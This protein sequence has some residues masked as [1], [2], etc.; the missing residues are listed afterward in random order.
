[1]TYTIGGRQISLDKDL[2]E[3]E[4]D[5]IVAHSSLF[6]YCLNNSSQQ[7]LINLKRIIHLYTDIITIYSTLL[8]KIPNYDD[9]TFMT[10]KTKLSLL[11]L[12]DDFNSILGKDINGDKVSWEERSYDSVR[13]IALLCL[14][15]SNEILSAI[16]KNLNCIDIFFNSF[17]NLKKLLI[18]FLLNQSKSVQKSINKAIYFFKLTTIADD[19]DRIE[20]TDTPVMKQLK[21]IERITNGI[22]RES[23]ILNTAFQTF[24]PSLQQYTRILLGKAILKRNIQDSN[25]QIIKRRD[26]CFQ[27]ADHVVSIPLTE[28]QSSNISMKYITKYFTYLI[29]IVLFLVGIMIYRLLKIFLD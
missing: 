28:E 10:N 8:R 6:K 26:I 22:D 17:N 9:I 12:E 20:D 11:K 7:F 16:I 2:Y 18:P 15:S 29:V 1:M 5:I 3:S 21:K 25:C 24:D 4:R 19:L 14:L 13:R 27:A 23:I